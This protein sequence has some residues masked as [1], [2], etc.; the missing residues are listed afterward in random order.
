[1]GSIKRAVPLATWLT[2]LVLW[3]LLTLVYLGRGNGLT[4]DSA[5]YIECAESIAAGR[6]F[7]VRPFGGLDARLWQ[8]LDSF[9]PGYPL[10]TAGLMRLGLSDAYLAARTVSVVCSG[11]FLVLMVTFYARTLP[12]AASMLLGMALVATPRMLSYETTCLSESAYTLLA[13]ISLF[14]LLRGTSDAR[15]SAAWLLAAG[16]VAGCAWCV[17][18]VGVALLLASLVYLIGQSSRFRLGRLALAAGVW[19]TGWLVAAGWLLIWDYRTFGTLRPYRMPAREL[20]AGS[21][22]IIA[23][24]VVITAAALRLLLR[25]GQSRPAVGDPRVCLL[26]GFLLFHVLTIIMAHCVYRLG[27]AASSFRFYM[28]V[29]WIGLWIAALWLRRLAGRSKS[30]GVAIVAAGVVWVVSMVVGALVP[31]AGRRPELDRRDAARLGRQIPS[32]KL[33]LGDDVESLRVFGKINARR[34]PDR[35]YG[36]VPLAWADIRAAGRD[37]RL[38]GIAVRD[39]KACGEGRFG[40]ALRRLG[41]TT[42]GLPHFRKINAESQMSV[43]QFVP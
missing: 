8:P 21:A 40:E 4:P 42:D 36:Q 12:A 30:V 17:R 7:Q 34:L 14:L 32:D 10:L 39:E 33:V 41:S 1:M 26:G 31:S 24:A 13:A 27:E 11:L 38:W 35:A 5:S 37:G 16:L 3:L 9:P 18:N 15:A 2:P 28:P 22:A 43:W 25:R 29:Y 6:G 23:L 19:L 20:S